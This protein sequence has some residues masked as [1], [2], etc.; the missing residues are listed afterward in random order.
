MALYTFLTVVVTAATAL[1]ASSSITAPDTFNL[2]ALEPTGTITPTLAASIISADPTASRTTYWIYCNVPGTE[3]GQPEEAPCNHLHG[4]SVTV[5][6][7]AMTVTIKRQSQVIDARIPTDN[8]GF[9]GTR[10]TLINVY[11]SP[12]PPQALRSQGQIRETYK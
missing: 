12:G 2:L 11:A 9:A 6:P 4:A 7:T 5:D 3:F 8:P 1:A 10:E